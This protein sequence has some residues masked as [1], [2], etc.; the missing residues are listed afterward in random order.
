M[1]VIGVAHDAQLSKKNYALLGSSSI[2][3]GLP[4]KS[5]ANSK[6]KF[7]LDARKKTKSGRYCFTCAA[8]WEQHLCADVTAK[9]KPDTV[10]SCKADHPKC[11]PGPMQTPAPPRTAHPHAPTPGGGSVLDF[12]DNTPGLCDQ[13]ES[14]SES[15]SDGSDREE[16]GTP[17]KKNKSSGGAGV[18]QSPRG[19]R[20]ISESAVE[21]VLD[22]A[23]AAVLRAKREGAQQE[24]LEAKG[25]T[26]SLKRK[27][28]AKFAIDQSKITTAQAGQAQAEAGRARAEQKAEAAEGHRERMAGT[29]QEQGM[30]LTEAQAQVKEL[31]RSL[32]LRK[33]VLR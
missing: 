30:Q 25:H 2:I 8:A 27:L 10:A 12:D 13:I 29:L 21:V 33:A 24:R 19:T 17:A 23:A 28:T 26:D 16:I 1:E 14:G 20:Y 22:A 9:T 32:R 6:Y 31:Q 18:Y 7:L 3:P 4:S 11:A 5:T 15:D